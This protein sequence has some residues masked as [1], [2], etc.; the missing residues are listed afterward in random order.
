[1]PT[2]TLD[3]IRRY[4]PDCDTDTEWWHLTLDGDPAEEPTCVRCG[5]RARVEGSG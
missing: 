4:C 1:M 5:V 3:P 2:D